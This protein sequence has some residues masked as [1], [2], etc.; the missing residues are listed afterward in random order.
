MPYYLHQA[1]YDSDGWAALVANPHD[2]V[3]AVRAT[4]EGLGGTLEGMWLAFGDVDVVA[5][6]RMPDDVSAAAVSIAISAGHAVRSVRTTP[7]LTFDDGVKAMRKASGSGYRPPS[8]DFW[9][10]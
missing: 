7:L 10:R 5:I 1:A 2:R 9:K 4:V 8:D 6:F 3:A